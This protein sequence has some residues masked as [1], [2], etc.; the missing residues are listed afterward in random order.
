M[1]SSN[2]TQMSDRKAGTRYIFL[3]RYETETSSDRESNEA[4]GSTK[5]FPRAFIPMSELEEPL[6][7]E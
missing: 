3:T 1:T 4:T 2:E 6:A 5:N 7:G